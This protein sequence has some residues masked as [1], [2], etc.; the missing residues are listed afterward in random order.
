MLEY[1]L[2]G[3]DDYELAFSATSDHRDAISA[4]SNDFSVRITKIGRAVDPLDYNRPE[5]QFVD[6]SG[7]TVAIKYPGYQHF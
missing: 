1:I 5:V 7:S 6:A 4:L 3:G 2:G